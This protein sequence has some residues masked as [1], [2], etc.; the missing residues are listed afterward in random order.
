MKR[1]SIVLVVAASLLSFAGVARAQPAELPPL[2]PPTD[3]APPPPAPAPDAQPAPPPAAPTAPAPAFVSPDAPAEDA[4]RDKPAEEPARERSMAVLLNPV[5]LI[6][7]T[8]S[9]DLVWAPVP[10]HAVLVSPHVRPIDGARYSGE[11]GYRYYTSSQR[12]PGGFFAG[13]VIAGFYSSEGSKIGF[14]VDV[15][16]QVVSKLGITASGGLGLMWIPAGSKVELGSKV[17]DGVY[18]E[19]WRFVPRMLA[20]VGYAF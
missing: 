19:I 9:L 7:K 8:L 10:H 14:A 16:V 1:A 4:N 6:S 15:G 12:E 18:A 3:P 2:P 20:S 17:G 5:P 13:P 11:L